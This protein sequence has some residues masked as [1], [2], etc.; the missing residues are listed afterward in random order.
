[1]PELSDKKQPF[2]EHLLEL[3][4]CLIKAFLGW[5]V[6]CIVVYIFTDQIIEFLINPLKPFLKEEAKV[7]FKTLPEVFANQIKISVILGFVIGSPYIIY[8]LWLFVA[9]GLYP[10]EKRWLKSAL[11]LSSF[12]FLIGAVTAFFL[13]LPFILK[14]LH[15]FGAQFLVFK[16]Y[17][18][19]YI[20]FLLKIL[21]IFGIF[22]QV[23]SIIFLLYKMDIVS[24]EQLKRFRP[25]A[26]V[27]SFILASV[28]TTGID[29]LNQI[30]LALPLTGLY[31]IGI[32]IIKIHNL[33]R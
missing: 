22:F 18:K 24:L 21:V 6:S 9:P 11:I 26:I 14:F 29:P 10:Q 2:I 3:R 30:L 25:Y 8:Q 20:N 32:M 7:Y 12:S 4:A 1:M 23:P 16:P 33:R 31:E 17:L 19:E 27:L 5:I 13:F 28:I 15:S